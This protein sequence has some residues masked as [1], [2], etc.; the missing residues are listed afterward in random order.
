MRQQHAL[1]AARRA[2]RVDHVGGRGGIDGHADGRR[3]G[4]AFG[5]VVDGEE[6]ARAGGQLRLQ[7]ALAQHQARSRIVEHEGQPLGRIGGIERHVGG[8]RLEDAHQ[9]GHQLRSAAQ[10]QA[11]QLARLHAQRQQPRGDA[12][13]AARQFAVADA[14]SAMHDGR[15]L[16]RACRL[17]ID[18]VVRIAQRAQGQA[19][20]VPV[21][22]QQLPLRGRQ[23]VQLRQRQGGVGQKR[24]Q[25]L[26]QVVRPG[27]DAVRVEQVQREVEPAR[28]AAAGGIIEHQRQVERRVLRRVG[29]KG[30][31]GLE[32][33]MKAVAARRLQ[34]L[35]Q[36]RQARG[37]A[38]RHGQGGSGLRQQTV[39]RAGVI[40]A[41]AQRGDGIGLRGADDQV[42]LAAEAGQESGPGRQQHGQRRRFAVPGQP[43]Q[44]CG[45]IAVD[46]EGHAADA[47]ALA[48]RPGAHAGQ[49]QQ[50]GGAVQMLTPEIGLLLCQRGGKAVNGHGACLAAMPKSVEIICQSHGGYRKVR[51]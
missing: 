20:G 11:D 2:G 28:I 30:Q 42:L 21:V 15:A 25:Q 19:A 47:P 14:V 35:D 24:A 49:F 39:A 16:R 8:A 37:V 34:R 40:E 18:E 50:G 1:G 23:Q 31:H 48:G 7:R 29:A 51:Q 38:L 3:I 13:G 45:G 46:G 12:V 4:R 6:G 27:G 26:L 5:D 17:G 22:Q 10:V 44:L 36:L 41:Q 9:A 33:G 32:Q 43:P